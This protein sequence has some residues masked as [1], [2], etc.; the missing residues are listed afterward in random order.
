M[1]RICEVIVCTIAILF[2][3]A[4]VF[5]LGYYAGGRTADT[6]PAVVTPSPTPVVTPSPTPEAKLPLVTPTQLDRALSE[7]AES[8]VYT[9]T[10]QTVKTL[11]APEGAEPVVLDCQGLIRL[12]CD[13]ETVTLELDREQGV[14]TVILPPVQVLDCWADWDS[15]RIRDTNTLPED[16][17]MAEYRALLAEVELIGPELAEQQ[18]IMEAARNHFRT[19]IRGAFAQWPE[20]EVVF[21]ETA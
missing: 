15:L 6:P 20:Y 8:G 21:E 3:A 1:K 10:Y 18:G 16:L 2:A 19:L 14:I 11:E 17:D 9:G 4:V 5:G 12:G 7:L 13:P